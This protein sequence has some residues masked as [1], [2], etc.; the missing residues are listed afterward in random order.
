MKRFQLLLIAVA[1]M[2]T[3]LSLS[4][5]E[6]TPM[7]D[8]RNMVQKVGSL[9]IEQDIYIEGFIIS[10]VKG[11]NNEMNEQVHFA[12]F[13]NH[14]LSTGYI[15]SVKGDIGFRINFASR[16]AVEEF[17]RYAKVVVSLKG[18]TLVC[19][20][21]CRVTIKGLSDTHIVEFTQCTAEDLPR[22]AK[23]I[24][25]ITDDDVYTYITLRDCEVLFHDGALSNVY[26]RY[27]LA[28]N[29]NKHLTPNKTMDCWA[30]LICDKYGSHI[31]SLTNALCTWRRD[32]EG[33]PQGAGDMRGILVCS[34]LARYG[35]D[36]FGKYALRPVDKKDYAMEWDASEAIYKPIAEWNWNDNTPYLNTEEGKLKTISHERVLSDV[37]EGKLSIEAEGK[38]SRA[39]DTNNPCIN[40]PKDGKTNGNYGIVNYGALCIRTASHNWWDWKNDCGKG[41]VI[42]FSTKR[43]SGKSLIFGFSFAAGAITANTSYGYPVFWNVEYSTNGTDWF[44]VEGSVPKKMRSLPWWYYNNV[45]GS[46]YVSEIAGAGFTEHMVKLPNTLFKQKT[47]YVRVVPVTKRIGTLGYDYNENGALRYNSMS[48]SVVNFGSIVVRYN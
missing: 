47:V 43:V 40:S 32:G 8:L 38:V 11:C 29:I 2:V 31:Y 37:G 45:N 46:N 10:K 33:A 5:V 19:E 28:S 23:Y 18:T 15:E 27:M 25:E 42:E 16:K 14:D 9:T 24:S 26:E 35:G 13:K 41:I 17:P 1:M 3:P 4:A 7:R 12:S 36:V 21:P 6:I 44:A 48:E 30:T 39:K 22:K 34:Q 20:K